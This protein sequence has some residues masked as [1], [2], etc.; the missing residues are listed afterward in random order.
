MKDLDLI[1]LFL[2]EGIL[3]FFEIT[4]VK[5]YPEMFEIYLSEKNTNH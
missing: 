5:K 2:P 1:S 4:D 3:D